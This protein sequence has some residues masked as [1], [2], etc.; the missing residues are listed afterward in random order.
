MTI[1]GSSLDPYLSFPRGEPTGTRVDRKKIHHS[2][3]LS[4]H[5][6]TGYPS[7]HSLLSP[8]RHSR[9]VS[10]PLERPRERVSLV[11]SFAEVRSLGISFRAE[12]EVEDVHRLRVRVRTR[13]RSVTQGEGRRAYKSTPVHTE[14]PPLNSR[15]TPPWKVRRSVL[16]APGEGGRGGYTTELAHSRVPWTLVHTTCCLGGPPSRHMTPRRRP[17]SSYS[18]G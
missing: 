3:V 12:V 8:L 5:L 16:S 17:L 13:R 10:T 7:G 1:E 6:S 15:P 14:G 4:V 18:Q 11:S 9:S 2:G